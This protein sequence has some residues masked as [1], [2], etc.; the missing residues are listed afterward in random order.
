MHNNHKLSRNWQ[1]VKGAT[2]GT[3]YLCYVAAVVFGDV[4]FITL[5]AATF[6]AGFLGYLAMAGAVV[7]A[8]TACALLVGKHVWFTPGNQMLAAN[9]F[10]V[11]ELGV[12]AMNTALAAAVAQGATL[13]GPLALWHWVSPVTPFVCAAGWGVIF[14][15]DESARARNAAAE[16]MA[17]VSEMYSNALRLAADDG[18]VKEQIKLGASQAARL[19]VEEVT[20]RAVAEVHD[21]KPSVKQLTA[22]PVVYQRP[23][24]NGNGHSTSERNGVNPT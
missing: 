3:A 22:E 19:F 21:A 9:L 23:A 18:E 8:V 5:M 16:A 15:F 10:W 13:D 7:T 1:A 24:S 17:D 20:G 2:I 4:M 11:V 12:L 6:P 14:L